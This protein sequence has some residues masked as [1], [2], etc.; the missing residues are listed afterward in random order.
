MVRLLAGWVI[1]WLGCGPLAHQLIEDGGWLD[2]PPVADA[3]DVF[4]IGR[5]LPCISDVGD[6]GDIGRMMVGW[7]A[8]YMIGRLVMLRMCM[9]LVIVMFLILLVWFDDDGLC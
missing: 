7:L 3:S 1:G 5:H 9:M 4:R 8:G 6:V 2:D